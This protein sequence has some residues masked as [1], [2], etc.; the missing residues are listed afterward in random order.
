MKYIVYQIINNI[1]GKVYIGKHQTINVEDGYMGSGKYLRHAITKHGKENFTKR[2]LH[3]FDIEEDMNAKERELVTSAFCARGDTYNIC[4]GGAGGFSYINTNGLSDRTSN[5]TK[6]NAT[7]TDRYGVDNPSQV[8]SARAKIGAN[9]RKYHEAGHFDHMHFA[10]QERHTKAIINAQT[11]EARAKRK[12]TM[13]ATGHQ[14][15][16]RTLNSV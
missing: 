8:T 4:E 13:A 7:L 15:G 2:I 12:S 1:D 16:Q 5:R 9:S 14:R 11:E 6:A 3:V 10:G